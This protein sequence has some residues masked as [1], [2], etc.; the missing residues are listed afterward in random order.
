MMKRQFSI[1]LAAFILI[2]GSMLLSTGKSYAA[3]DNNNGNNWYVGKGIQPN[4][5][6]TYR[7][8]EHDT[9]SGKP[10]VM[11]IYFERFNNTGHYWLAPVYVA[12]PGGEVLNGTFHLSDLD[13][14]VLGTSEMPNNL[15]PYV[16]A[17]SL[18]TTSNQ[19]WS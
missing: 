11:T 5:Y 14:S 4:T 16:S 7:I 2:L 9:N 10:F 18:G 6:L 17:Y 13:L 1:F 15:S 8:Q 19:S 12:T 3:S